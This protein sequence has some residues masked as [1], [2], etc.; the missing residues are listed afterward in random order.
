MLRLH[1]FC[2]SGNSFKA[3]FTLRAMGLPYESVFVDFMNGQTRDAAWRAQTNAMGEA[4]VESMLH[5]V[6]PDDA[7]SLME[8]PPTLPGIGTP[9]WGE[10][11]RRRIGILTLV[12]PV[13]RGE[14]VRVSLP[15]GDLVTRAARSVS[16]AQHRRAE[17]K[18]REEVQ[19]VLLEFEAQP[20]R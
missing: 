17:R 10:P 18:A 15:V 14:I 9:T 16:A 2:Q 4:P 20:R 13:K 7:S 3:A 19:R 12:P 11:A 1:G 5:L 8:D 6:V